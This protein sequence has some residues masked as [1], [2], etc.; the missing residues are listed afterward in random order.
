MSFTTKNCKLLSVILC[1]ISEYN[2][3]SKR[4]IASL[5]K[6]MTLLLSVNISKRFSLNL[7]STYFR[8]SSVAGNV[9]GTSA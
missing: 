3:N 5:T 6:M 8:V 1:T 4:E 7:K 2:Y 9:P